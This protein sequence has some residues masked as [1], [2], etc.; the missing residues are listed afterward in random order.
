M[1]TTAESPERD[2]PPGD[3]LAIPAGP[4]AVLPAPL[5][6]RALRPPVVPADLSALEGPGSG[7]IELPVRLCWSEDDRHFDL[8]DRD[9]RVLMCEYVLDAGSLADVCHWLNADI[10]A[11][12]WPELAVDKAKAFA[13]EDRFPL[14]R[15]RRL[16][17]AA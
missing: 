1:S 4:G 12:A 7:L 17:A 3:G 13:W 9:D 14:L 15:R 6:E 2:T 10:L 11:E 8:D 16:A 5:P